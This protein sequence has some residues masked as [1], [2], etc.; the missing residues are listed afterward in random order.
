MSLNRETILLLVRHGYTIKVTG[1]WKGWKRVHVTIDTDGVKYRPPVVEPW[2]SI[3]I[4]TAMTRIVVL[5]AVARGHGDTFSI[6]ETTHHFPSYRECTLSPSFKA[7]MPEPPPVETLADRCMRA[8]MH[9]SE[10]F[11]D[12]LQMQMEP[13]LIRRWRRTAFWVPA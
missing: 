12:V 3:E 4:F 9:S 6:V 8:L 10:H 7:P 13:E 1:L 11:G 2:R 5:A